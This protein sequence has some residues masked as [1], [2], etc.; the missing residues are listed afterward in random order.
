M[1]HHRKGLFMDVK[2]QLRDL[3]ISE[4]GSVSAFA[5]EADLPVSTVFNVLR[6]GVDGASFEVVNK[7]YETLQVDWSEVMGDG[8]RL[9]TK[10]RNVE[11]GVEVGVF[12]RIAAGIPIEMMESNKTFF[13]PSAVRIAHPRAFYLEIDGESMNRVLP[14]GCYAL[15]DPDRREVYDNRAYAVCV[16]GYDATVKRV[17]KLANGFQLV[18][19]SDDPTYPIRTY[20]YNEEGTETITVIGEVVWY[21]VP[22]GFEI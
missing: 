10:R 3:M 2:D 14:N 18:P 22:F 12:G 19:D 7:I 15:V 11:T 21:S 20:N 16:N 1:K 6:R 8:G 5:R 9:K 4:F 13:V 17:R